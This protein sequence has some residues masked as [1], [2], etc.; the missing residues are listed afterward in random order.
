[1]FLIAALQVRLA[2]FCILLDKADHKALVVQHM[3]AT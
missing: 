3:D 1:M 2:E